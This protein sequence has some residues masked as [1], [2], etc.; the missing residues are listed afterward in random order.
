MYSALGLTKDHRAHVGLA[1]SHSAQV[2]ILYWMRHNETGELLPLFMPVEDMSVLPLCTISAAPPAHCVPANL[3]MA[4][5]FQPELH[6]RIADA[7]RL[8]PATSHGGPAAEMF[9]LDDHADLDLKVGSGLTVQTPGDLTFLSHPKLVHKRSPTTP[10]SSS[11][12]APRRAFLLP[13]SAMESESA[14]V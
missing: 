12:L 9:A 5:E 2:S 11:P 6:C 4:M 8:L 14:D 13:G 7:L 10:V 3:T 1:S